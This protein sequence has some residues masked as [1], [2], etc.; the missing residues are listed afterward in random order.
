MPCVALVVA[1]TDNRVIGRDNDLPWRL[2]SDL[3]YFKK[4]AIATQF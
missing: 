1:M 3:K 4:I 2:S